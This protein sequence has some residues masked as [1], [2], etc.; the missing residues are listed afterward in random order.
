MPSERIF[1]IGGP[2][3]G[4]TTLAME[5]GR[6]TGLPVHALDEV[7]RVGGGTG[8]ER[9]VDERAQSIAEILA[10]GGWVAEG[11]HVGWSEPLLDA[12]DVII[13]LDHTAWRRSS[14]RIVRRFVS[15]AVA[16]A[17][18]RRGRAR[19]MRFRDYGRRLRDLAV[20]I[21]E[22]RAY[23]KGG[24]GRAGD[25]AQSSAGSR[26]ATAALLERY[27]DKVVHCTSAAD[28][29][30]ILSATGRPGPD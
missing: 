3:T 2:G 21:P 20:A 18:Q 5:L 28:V 10:S 9:T 26:A 27:A 23:Q 14:A 19:F 4:K 6:R 13:W 7:A 29:E 30:A 22:T 24:S 8:P 11:V 1:V 15:Q 17:R 16:E 25:T 12:A